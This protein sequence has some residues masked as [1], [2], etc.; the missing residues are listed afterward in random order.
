MPRMCII[1]GLEDGRA[2]CLV[3]MPYRFALLRLEHCLQE[4]ITM[5]M[6]GQAPKKV[7]K[8][9]LLSNYTTIQKNRVCGPISILQI[10]VIR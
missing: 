10:E 9:I 4:Y 3:K 7:V 5:A 6:F 1:M 2:T 8:L